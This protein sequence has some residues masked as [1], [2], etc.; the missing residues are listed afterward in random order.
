MSGTKF[1]PLITIEGVNVN[2]ELGFSVASAGDVNNDGYDDII[3][4]AYQASPGGRSNAGEAYVIYGKS[5]FISVDLS[6]TLPTSSGFKVS[7]DAIDDQLGYSVASAGDVNNDRYDDIIIGANN[8][9]SGGRT[10]AGEAYIIYGNATLT[11]IDLSVTDTTLPSY[12]SADKGFRV[13][14]NGFYNL[15]NSVASAGDVNG[16]DYDDIIIGANNASSGGRSEAGEAYIIYG[17]S[18]LSDIDLSVTDRIL[19]TYFSSDRGFKISGSSAGGQLGVSVA[20][21]GDVNNDRYDDIIIGAYRANPGGRSRAGEAYIIYGNTILND[22]DLSVTDTTLPS[23][24]SA[25][26]GF[27]IL[28]GNGNDALGFSVSGAGNINNDGYDDIIIGAI[29]ADPGGRGEAGEAYVIYGNTA[30]SDIDL[31]VT[32]TTLPSYFSTDKGFRVLGKFPFDSLGRSVSGAGDVNNDGFGDVIIGVQ[33]ADPGGRLEAGE[34]Y[35]IYGNRTLSDID[36]S[37]TNTTSPSY[38]SY[39]RGFSVLGSNADDQLGSSVSGAG[40]VNNDGIDDIIIGAYQASPGGRNDAGEVYIINGYISTTTNASNI[41]SEDQVNQDVISEDI[42]IDSSLNSLTMTNSNIISYGSDIDL[43]ELSNFTISDSNIGVYG[44]GDIL[45]ISSTAARVFDLS[46]AVTAQDISFSRALTYCNNSTFIVNNGNFYSP[47]SLMIRNNNCTIPERDV[48]LDIDLSVTDTTSPNYFSIGRGFS[49]LGGAD[50]DEL[51]RS[52]NLLRD[53]NG[54]GIDDII[55]GAEDADPGGR[56][57]AGEAYII[58]GNATL[59]NID[60]S[61][62]DS[63]SPDY[64]SNLR[65]FRILGGVAGDDL[66]R[67]VASAGD[68]NRDGYN[69]IIIGAGSVDPG[70]RSNVGEAYVIYGN[71]TLSD[72]D[73]SITDSTS[74]D[75]FSNLRGFR[76][77]GGADGDNL[78]YS[79]ASAGDINNDGFED[80]VIVQEEHLQGVVTRQEKYM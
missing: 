47:H 28:G 40:D 18:T 57:N 10:S 32:D 13:L 73:L 44:Y 64:F 66:G 27:S 30:L 71:A 37:V 53:I 22:I 39:D 3:I 48:D 12:F 62:T 25:D 42:T 60:L 20:S 14:G 52:V 8:A 80:V 16:D 54:D 74:P 67:S 58:Y 21:A 29:G 34:A 56:S 9:D 31:S 68:I 50:E 17:N 2:D 45:D 11:D 15:G 7:G 49:V 5:T 78:G 24:F 35:V 72:I 6:T 77:L 61:V 65:G 23:Y 43:T 70:G 69:D 38:F 59:S 4:G 33:L 55:I 63:T 36:L 19:P 51:G 1:S 76:I 46:Q 26:K 41:T 79:V 75:Y